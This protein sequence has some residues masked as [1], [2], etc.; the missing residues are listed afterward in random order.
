MG[1]EIPENDEI[2]PMW[3][4]ENPLRLVEYLNT[5]IGDEDTILDVGCGTKAISTA[6]M[7]GPVTTIDAWK[8]FNPDIWLDL[9]VISKLPCE[10]DSF[11]VALMLD[12]IEHLPKGR[13][14]VVL[15]ELKRVVRKFFVVLTPLWW[16]PNLD[17]VQDPESPYYENHFDKHKSLW[18]P[19]DFIG[20]ERIMNI[21]TLDNYFLGIWRKDGTE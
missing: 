9:A 10:D 7:S 6:I 16:D 19:K 18:E 13:G 11:D 3:L 8:P 5:I 1:K 15:K 20:F 17:C 12:V 4:A 2:K 21:G 14:F